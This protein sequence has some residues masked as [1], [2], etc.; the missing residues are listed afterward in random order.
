M[1]K[2]CQGKNMYEESSVDESWSNL[3]FSEASH[4]WAAGELT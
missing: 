4:L 2:V 1:L 3:E